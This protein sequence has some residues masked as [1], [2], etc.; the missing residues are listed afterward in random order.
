[1]IGDLSENTMKK[2]M[3][4][5]WLLLIQNCFAGSKAVFDL[6]T[7]DG[8][9]GFVSYGVD[10]GGRAGFDVDGV[11]DINADG[12]DDFVMSAFSTNNFTGKVY[13]VFGDITGFDG[14]LQLADIDGTNGFVINGLQQQHVLGSSVSGIGDINN[15]GIDDFAIGARGANNNS[16]AV[17]FIFGSDSGFT[18]NINL[19]DLDGSNGFVLNPEPSSGGALGNSIAVAGDFNDDGINDVIIGANKSRIDFMGSQVGAAFILFGKNTFNATMSTTDLS[20]NAGKVI[21]GFI[22]NGRLGDSLASAGDINGDGVDD[23]V[24]SGHSGNGAEEYVYVVFG[25]TAD[26]PDE[27][28][29]S[30]LDGSNGFAI[31]G[32]SV[33]HSFGQSISSGFDINN[34][35]FSD[36]LIGAPDWT[37]I[38]ITQVGLVYV[39]YGQSSTF[40]AELDISTLDGEN[41]FIIHGE[42]DSFNGN[43]NLGNAVS[44]VGDF[45]NDAI[46]DIAVSTRGAGDFFNGSCHVIYGNIDGFGG[47]F[48]LNLLDGENGFTIF[49]INVSDNIGESLSQAGDVNNDGTMDF[50]IGTPSES[51]NGLSSGAVYTIFGQPLLFELSV[52]KTGSGTGIVT[53]DTGLIDCGDVCIDGYANNSIVTLTA[54]ADAGMEF[55]GWNG[56]GCSG[57][58]DCEVFID[59]T[60]TVTAEFTNFDVIFSDGFEF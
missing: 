55:T 24:M 41:G 26:F 38:D 50:M 4:I 18:L 37:S 29:V 31:K 40:S 44:S 52:M 15:D 57:T 53:A 7:L 9:N 23:L 43:I 30:S 49:G 14:E 60:V 45:N 28:N 1:M 27:F 32:E 58:A 2:I 19:N 56:G 12:I 10:D 16:G 59:Q 39:V 6:T 22:E 3:L 42:I 47:S 48:D 11:G 17:Y 5:G 20:G 33:D 51:T 35:G 13:A 36:V 46:D 34:D 21:Y 8:T 25:D 54:V